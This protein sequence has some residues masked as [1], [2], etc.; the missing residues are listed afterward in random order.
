MTTASQLAQYCVDH[1]FV[2]TVTTKGKSMTSYLIPG[3]LTFDAIL[4]ALAYTVGRVGLPAFW[5]DLKAL[6]SKVRGVASTP[7]TTPQAA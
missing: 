1:G 4:V 7:A 6:Y 3:T 5:A 2:H